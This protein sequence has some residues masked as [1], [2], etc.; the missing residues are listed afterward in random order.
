VVGAGVNAVS[1][2]ALKLGRSE[3]AEERCP[4]ADIVKS[5]R[6]LCRNEVSEWSLMASKR[7]GQGAVAASTSVESELFMI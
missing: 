4:G 5:P 6:M 7:S 2:T 1:L 3:P